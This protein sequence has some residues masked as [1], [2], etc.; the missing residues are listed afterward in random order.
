M[1]QKKYL[2]LLC[3]I[4]LTASSINASEQLRPTTTYDATEDLIDGVIFSNKEQIDHAIRNGANL[5]HKD[6]DGKSILQLAELF[7]SDINIKLY[8]AN[9][10]KNAQT[11]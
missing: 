3:W 8:L 11:K 7:Q 10:I 6:S 1:I 4:A 2:F 5:L 9:L